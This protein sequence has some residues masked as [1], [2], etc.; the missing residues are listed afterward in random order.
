VMGPLTEEECL[1]LM[2][3][4]EKLNPQAPVP[5]CETSAAS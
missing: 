2:N 4:L 5:V 1:Q 3:L